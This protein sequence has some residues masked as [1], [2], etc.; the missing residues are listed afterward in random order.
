MSEKYNTNKPG[1]PILNTISKF[2]IYYPLKIKHVFINSHFGKALLLCII[3]TIITLLIWYSYKINGDY[4]ELT[5]NEKE[6]I[7]DNVNKD[8]PNLNPDERKEKGN[9]IIE[10]KERWDRF[11][12]VLLSLCM[13]LISGII[14][15]ILGVESYK[16]LLE[17]NVLAEKEVL[18]TRSKDLTK[19]IKRK[20]RTVRIFN[21]KGE[22]D[23][24]INVNDMHIE[25]DINK[26]LEELNDIHIE[27]NIKK[28]LEQM[29]NI[30]IELEKI[31]NI[32]K[33]LEEFD[34]INKELEETK[35]I[36]DDN[37]KEEKIKRLMT[38]LLNTNNKSLDYLL[39][40]KEELRMKIKNENN[41]END[42]KE[43]I[44]LRM[45]YD[46][47]QNKIKNNIT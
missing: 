36:I 43:L 45:E 2:F 27:N 13:G 16:T 6:Q 22:D 44:D 47:L 33:L 9:N 34:S 25:N 29:N 42:L 18:V 10:Q 24:P 15:I 19:K 5:D 21:G 20:L 26:E 8:F 38:L 17:H 35:Y 31:K 11:A 28:E 46:L 30:S 37:K 41:E 1:K 39:Q 40:T 32:D 14:S 12:T 4:P 7:N 23:D 3:I